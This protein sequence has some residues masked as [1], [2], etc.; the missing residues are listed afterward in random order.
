MKAYG[1]NVRHTNVDE[2][3]SISILSPTTWQAL[4]SPQLVL[5][6]QNLLNFNRTI[7]EPLG[8]LPKLPIT[9]E[10]KI[11]CIDLMVFQGQLD[12]D[13]ILLKDYVYVMK[14][15]ISNLVHMMSFPHNGNIVTV[16][17][18]SYIDLSSN[19][20]DLTP[21][22]VPYMEVVPTPSRLIMW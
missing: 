17:Q 11:V 3:A 15:V 12:F 22:N 4:G 9:M 2:G 16:D 10:G 8:I 19:T 6:T 20:S 1:K 5:V 18:L 7:S 13:F 21:L 14:V